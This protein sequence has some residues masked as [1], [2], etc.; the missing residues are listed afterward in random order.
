MKNLISN[1]YQYTE[2]QI[3]KLIL[4]NWDNQLKHFV[5]VMPNEYRRALN[6][7]QVALTKEVA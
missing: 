5:K 4:E 1:H 2:S 3:A 6:G 7:L